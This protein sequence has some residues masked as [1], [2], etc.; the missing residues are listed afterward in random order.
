M[1]D[2][3]HALEFGIFPS[4]DAA[5]PDRVL[6]LAQLADVL[7]LDLV[8]VQDHPYQARHL[9][10]WTLLSVVAARTTAVR[11]APNVVNLPLRPPAVLAQ[12][13]ASLD[14]L[15]GGRVEL[16]LGAGAFWDA[17]VAAGG[18][19]L[20]PGQAVDALVEAIAVLR[21]SWSG[22]GS[23]RVEGEHHRVVGL[24]AGPRPA[25]PVGIW[26]GAYGPRMLGVTGRLADGWLPSMGYADP[27]A[28]GPMNAR[29][30]DAAVGAGRAS[31]DVRRLYNVVPAGRSGSGLRG[32]VTDWPEQLAGLTLE[33][34]MATF[35]LG[36]D[37]PDLVRAWASE[38]APATRELVD[39]ER[40]AA[41]VEVDGPDAGGTAV[42]DAPGGPG[43]AAGRRDEAVTRSAAASTRP[44][45]TPA[46]VPTPDDGTRLTG[47]LPWDE[48]ARP[49]H[50]DRSDASGYGDA[51]LAAP[52]HLVDVHDHLRSELA[53]V[54]DVVDQVARGMLS[55]GA[56]RSAV[57][58]MTMRQNQW[59]LG[60][61]CEAYCRVVT[62]H[63]TLEDQA[64]FPRLRRR[65]PDAAPVI[66][67]LEEEHEVIHDVLDDVDRALVALV[68]EEDGALDRLRHVVDLLTDTLL[69]HLA[70]EERELMHPLARHGMF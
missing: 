50:P 49:V 35:V 3:G 1:T 68:S 28:L 51:E 52:R 24:H 20:G 47:E 56:A 29:I 15:T 25:H 36:T 38:V 23:V 54:R 26:V 46:F 67:R 69:S 40:A 32:R 22:E 27:D 16:G 21:A 13:V 37:D 48:A 45:A 11:V 61:Y 41:A 4:P 39:A 7:G 43:D 65:D 17:I 9:D 55:V 6:E 58:A 59:T 62:G 60:A 66:A 10:A 63:H 53:Q 42:G 34:G 2:Y 57:N 8:T 64:M 18:E 31:E 12:A 5:A 44:P 14:L 30:D 33:H 70:Y 19:R